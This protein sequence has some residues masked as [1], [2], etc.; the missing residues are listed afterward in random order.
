MTN[1][2]FPSASGGALNVQNED[3]DDNANEE[4]DND[5]IEAAAALISS[6]AG[7][8]IAK[9]EPSP[10]PPTAAILSVK[11]KST[12][13]L[14]MHKPR[15]ASPSP[16]GS[17]QTKRTNKRSLPIK[18]KKV[19]IDIKPEGDVAEVKAMVVDSDDGGED[20]AVAAVVEET[21]TPTQTL[22]STLTKGTLSSLTSQTTTK[23]RP[24]TPNRAIRMPPFSSPGLLIP[25]NSSQTLKGKPP[26]NGLTTISSVFD[27]YLNM[28]VGY[29]E[30]SRTKKAYVGS[31]LKRQIGDT[32]DSNVKFSQYFPR[33]VPA[34]L[35]PPK[36]KNKSES[37]DDIEM[38]G[39]AEH[40][41]HNLAESL[42]R[43]FDTSKNT[44]AHDQ[45]PKQSAEPSA[46]KSGNNK[47]VKNSK[48]QPKKERKVLSFSEMIPVSLT[49]PYPDWFVQERIEYAERIN[50]R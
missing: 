46:A 37:D 34:D 12:S 20:D 40:N 38:N 39:D 32:F 4:E 45:V 17:S 48:E 18:K 49:L 5:E 10:P 2:P 44:S 23:K 8:Q 43:A 13:P 31:S 28:V 14:P 29:S 50:E 35:V 47:S 25:A 27:Q 15:S 30:E 16:H 36:L 11:S 42:I 9:P 22:S 21:I 6:A 24:G 19:F 7:P 26:E 33:L 1:M 3:K 41:H